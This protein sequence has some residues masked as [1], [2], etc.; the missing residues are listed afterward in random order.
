MKPPWDWT[1]EEKL[2]GFAVGVGAFALWYSSRSSL[3]YQE[4]QIYKGYNITATCGGLGSNTC[5]ASWSVKV[6]GTV[7]SDQIVGAIS[8]AAALSAARDKI[9]SYESSYT[10]A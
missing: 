10:P 3:G 2:I 6:N 5:V 9:D 4:S 7:F 1:T 8:A